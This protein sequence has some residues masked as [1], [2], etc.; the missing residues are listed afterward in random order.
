[1]AGGGTSAAEGF[2]KGGLFAGGDYR[3]F[4]AWTAFVEVLQGLGWIEGKN[5]TFEHRFAN[6]HSVHHH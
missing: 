5:F 2:P 3:L 1:V 6:D 4:A